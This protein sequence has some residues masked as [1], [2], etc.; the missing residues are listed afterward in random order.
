M[1]KT[2]ISI[3]AKALRFESNRMSNMEESTS[4][5]ADHP[6]R[7]E[8]PTRSIDQ[9][10]EEASN[11]TASLPSTS[12]IQ[13]YIIFL[14]LGIA[15]SGDS[16]EIT[17]MNFILSNDNF[18]L[19]ILNDDLATHGSVLAACVF[20][21]MLIGGLLTGAYGDYAGRRSTLL[22]GLSLNSVSGI[23]SAF[24][25]NF[26]SLCFLRFLAGLGIGAILSSL[27]TLATESSPPSKRG[28]NVSFVG[29][30]FTLGTVYVAYLAY[31]LFGKYDVSWRI[32]VGLCAMPSL[33]GTI[34]VY[35]FVPESAR[36]LALRDQPENATVAANQIANAMGYRGSMLRVEEVRYHHCSSPDSE[37][38]T[39]KTF[40]RRTIDAMKNIRKLYTKNIWT[41]TLTLQMIWICLSFGAGLSTWINVVLKQIQVSNVYLNSLFYSLS[42]I[43]GNILAAFLIDR[44]GRKLLMATSMIFASISLFF[45]ARVAIEITPDLASTAVIYACV[46]HAFVVIAW[47]SVNVITSESFPTEVRSTGLGV[48]AAT[49]RLVGI[50]VQYINGSLVDRPDLI[51]LF[52]SLAMFIGSVF[53]ISL[54]DM[55]LRPLRD[56]IFFESDLGMNKTKKSSGIELPKYRAKVE[57]V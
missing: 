26:G 42:S 41:K 5:N 56:S 45:F 8:T 18:V 43:P 7:D 55:S 27:V 24:V 20:A 57:L 46:F 48:C 11:E 50:F 54:R 23:F 38:I 22:L 52:S 47:T 29:A 36:Y 12:R 10:Y 1:P 2:N 25:P 30:F 34:L 6:L 49:S 35:L 31:I 40:E 13:Y 21:G 16:A 19:S 4:L 9:F 14:A 37:K 17:N 51:I 3:R 33:I 15:N 28:R 53:S 32:F 44:L 39:T